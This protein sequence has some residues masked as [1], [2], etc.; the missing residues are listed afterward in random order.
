MSPFAV[1]AIELLREAFEPARDPVRAAGMKA[2][3]RNQFEFLGI[4]TTD[5]R[6]LAR[7]A[8]AQVPKPDQANLVELSTALYSLREREYHYAAVDYVAA[9]VRRC[10]AGFISHV[11]ELVTTNSWWDTV[12]G[13]AASVA[14]PLVSAHP[15]LVDEM[16]RW[17]EDENLWVVRT[18]ILHQLRYKERTDSVRLFEYC[19]RQASHRDFFIRKAIGW[20][21]R[22]YSKTDPQ[23]VREFIDSHADALSGL[24]K[25]EG[26]LWITGRKKRPATV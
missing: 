12:D 2:Y 4:P 25:R 21:L 19:E 15:Q 5:R 11:R 9:H 14:G 6:R 13:L 20:A 24:S 18:A 7:E 8:L 17:I 16:D 22:E 26:M 1:A 10:S 3:M 23:A